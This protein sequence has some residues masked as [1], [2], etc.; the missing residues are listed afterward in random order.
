MP[1][2]ASYTF[3]CKLNHYETAVM[4]GR[5][6]DAGWDVVTLQDHPDLVIIDSC[7]VTERADTKVR[8]KIRRVLRENP[9]AYLIV[10]GCL[11]QRDPEMIAQI[12]GVNLVLGNREKLEPLSYLNL[13][14]K[15]N[16]TSVQ[17]DRLNGKVRDL[18]PAVPLP[19]FHNQTRG[20]MKVQDGC[21]TFCSFCIVPHVR[22][23]SRS[24]DPRDVVTQARQLTQ[25]GFR[26]LV[27]TGVH[28][29]DFGRDLPGQ[30]DLASLLEMLSEVKQLLRI[31]ISSI[32]PWDITE[33]LLTTMSQLPQVMPHLH[34]AIQSASDSVLKRMRRRNSAEDLVELMTTQ[35]QLLPDAAVGTDV[36]TGFPGERD[37]DFEETVQFLRQ[38]QL[39]YLHVFPYSVREGTP[40]ATMNDQIST[41]VKTERVKKLLELDNKLRHDFSNRFLNSVQE[42]LVESKLV[43]D[44]LSGRTP[45][46]LPVLLPQ[47]QYEANQIAKVRLVE[48]NGEYIR[49]VP[50]AT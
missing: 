42:V 39:S 43:N 5:F 21:D 41:S 15:S 29:G 2:V 40:A 31:R 20:F 36:L 10:S 45:Q 25:N 19:H 9:A 11:A 34:M 28:I 27:L 8:R 17:V 46:Y 35:R 14:Q 3:G 48:Q 13:D 24:L 37:D 30:V 32:E 44:S 16:A 50:V 7:T 6:V 1:T 26:E 47:G 22:G 23:R 4:I 18:L 49:T 33:R 12:S 38:Q